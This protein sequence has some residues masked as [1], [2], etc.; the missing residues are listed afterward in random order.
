MSAQ[1]E[2]LLFYTERENSPEKIRYILDRIEILKA[3]LHSQMARQE[4]AD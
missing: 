1:L 3:C 4:Q 2:E